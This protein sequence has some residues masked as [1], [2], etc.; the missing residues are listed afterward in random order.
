MSDKRDEIFRDLRAPDTTSVQEILHKLSQDGIQVHSAAKAFF[1][2]FGGFSARFKSK[3]EG[4]NWFHFDLG[5]DFYDIDDVLDYGRAL[6]KSLCPIG[7]A[8]RDHLYLVMDEEGGVYGYFSP[9]IF[10][11]GDD[12]NEAIENICNERNDLP[13]ATYE[14]RPIQAEDWQY[15]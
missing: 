14:G 6:G 12:Y 1:A 4:F 5:R 3:D 13:S 2:K 8:D 7:Q 10:K 11:L 15:L 9:Y